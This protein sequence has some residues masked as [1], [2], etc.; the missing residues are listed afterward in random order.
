MATEA[1]HKAEEHGRGCHPARGQPKLVTDHHHRR[2]GQRGD[3]IDL[4]AQDGRHL[5]HQ[6]IARHA[7]AYGGQHPEQGRRD[8]IDAVGQGLLRAGDGKQG[9]PGR[10]QQHNQVI[11]PAHDAL[12]RN[13][14]SPARTGTRT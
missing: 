13:R 6:H 3:G 9:Q 7:A 8:G 11:Q 2:A 12:R 10:I 5:V 4:T 1:E 14:V